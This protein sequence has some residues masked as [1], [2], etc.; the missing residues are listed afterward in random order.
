MRPFDLLFRELAE[1]LPDNNVESFQR[2]NQLSQLVYLISKQKNMPESEVLKLFR[3]KPRA[4]EMLLSKKEICPLCAGT[5]LVTRVN[6]IPELQV[7]GD[8]EYIINCVNSVAP[9]FCEFAVFTKGILDT[10]DLDEI[11]RLKGRRKK[12]G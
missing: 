4:A 8:Y 10:P 9:E 3:V 11:L 2:L 1:R 12:N 5:L 6:T 7:G